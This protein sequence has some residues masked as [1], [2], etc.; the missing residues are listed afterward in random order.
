MVCGRP[1]RGE[2]FLCGVASGRYYYTLFCHVRIIVCRLEGL[3]F[4]SYTVHV[5]YSLSLYNNKVVIFFE[6]SCG[7]VRYTVC[8][9]DS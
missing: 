3:G 2:K 1:S 7:G 9:Q 5:V 6:W 8:H 4:I